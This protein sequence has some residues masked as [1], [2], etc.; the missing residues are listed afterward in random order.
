M[1]RVKFFSAS[2]L[3]C[4]E[5]SIND[6]FKEKDDDIGKINISAVQYKDHGLPMFFASITYYQY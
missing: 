1:N 4:L 5:K 3:E 2:S 6:W